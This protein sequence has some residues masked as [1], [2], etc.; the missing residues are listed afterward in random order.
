MNVF[1]GRHVFQ[2]MGWRRHAAFRAAESRNAHRKMR[3][4]SSVGLRLRPGL[5]LRHVAAAPCLMLLLVMSAPLDADALGRQG[6]AGSPSLCSAV[7]RGLIRAVFEFLC[8]VCILGVMHV[9][10][11]LAAAAGKLIFESL[12]LRVRG[13]TLELCM[14]R[15][16]PGCDERLRFSRKRLLDHYMGQQVRQRTCSIPAVAPERNESTHVKGRSSAALLLV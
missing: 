15:S 4:G 5:K 2:R 7:G 6:K 9:L 16:S 3:W 14:S 12:V 13:S 11:E 1:T 10:D 8:G